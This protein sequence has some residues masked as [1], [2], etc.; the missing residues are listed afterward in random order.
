MGYLVWFGIVALVFALMHYF[1]ELSGK[2]KGMISLVVT[3]VIAAA[4]AYNI[5]SDRDRA[6]VSAI[7]LKYERGETLVCQGIEVNSSTF[8]YSVGTQSFV[9]NRG[10]QYYQQIINARECQ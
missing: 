7:E 1:T 10:T 3:L 8:G 6:K 9:G 5:Q 2:Q 4:I